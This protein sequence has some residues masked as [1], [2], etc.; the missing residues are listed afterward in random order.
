MC[1]CMPAC[2]C[3]CMRMHVQLVDQ[4]QML[5][6]SLYHSQPYYFYDWISRQICSFSFQLYRLASKQTLGSVCLCP[7][8]LVLGLQRHATDPSF[9]VASANLS[10]DSHACVA[11]TWP[12][13]P[14]SQ[15]QIIITNENIC[16]GSTS[17]R[18]YNP[19]VIWYKYPCCCCFNYFAVESSYGTKVL[20]VSWRDCYHFKLNGSPSVQKHKKRSLYCLL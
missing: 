13:E 6:S 11:S 10:S 14:S 8:L 15:A 17:L 4:K 20:V 12:I 1:A 2:V 18:V 16:F 7:P 19:K 9:P 5:E 3:V